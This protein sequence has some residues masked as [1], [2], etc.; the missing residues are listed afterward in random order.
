MGITISLSFRLPPIVQRSYWVDESRTGGRALHPVCWG[1]GVLVIQLGAGWICPQLPILGCHWPLTLPSHLRLSTT[2]VFH[3][4]TGGLGSLCPGHQWAK[5][6]PAPPHQVGQ[7]VWL[8][9]R[10]L[11]LKISCQKLA[12]RFVGPFPISWVLNPVAVWLKLPRVLRLHPTFH[13][14]RL[15][16]VWACSLVCCALCFW[17]TLL[18]FCCLGLLPVRTFPIF[19]VFCLLNCLLWVSIFLCF[20]GC[21]LFFCPT[22]CWV[23]EMQAAF[24]YLFLLSTLKTRAC[25]SYLRT[26][27]T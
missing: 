4:G 14:S 22:F 13:A 23:F 24:L 12:P 9:T 1:T 26:P 2:A 5:C 3:P 17:I 7:S 8:S 20:C 16:P 11:P 18:G 19:S 27:D 15:K 25:G 6:H 21:V 10:D